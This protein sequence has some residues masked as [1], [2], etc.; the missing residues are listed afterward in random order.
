M[1]TS[2][3]SSMRRDSATGVI[4]TD[5]A[6][7]SRIS[8]RMIP[9]PDE[10]SAAEGSS[11]SDGFEREVNRRESQ[12]LGNLRSHLQGVPRNPLTEADVTSPEPASLRGR[13]LNRVSASAARDR[14]IVDNIYQ[15][16][17]SLT[18]L[19]VVRIQRMWRGYRTRKTMDMI[20]RQGQGVSDI[21]VYEVIRSALNYGKHTIDLPAFRHVPQGIYGAVMMY[22]KDESP[23]AVH[24][25]KAIKEFC[26]NGGACC[27]APGTKFMFLWLLGTCAALFLVPGWLAITFKTIFYDGDSPLT[28]D[29]LV[30]WIM[31]F[32]LICCLGIGV[33]QAWCIFE[34]ERFGA[35]ADFIL[36]I[37]GMKKSLLITHDQLKSLR[38]NALGET[39]RALYHDTPMAVIHGLHTF[40]GL[41]AVF[42][43]SGELGA[44]NLLTI[45]LVIVVMIMYDRMVITQLEITEAVSKR[46]GAAHFYSRTDRNG[47]MTARDYQLGISKALQR[48]SKTFRNVHGMVFSVILVIYISSVILMFYVGGKKASPHTLM[49]S[50]CYYFFTQ[51]SFWR[52]NHCYTAVLRARV[53]MNRLFKVIWYF[54]YYGDEDTFRFAEEDC[55]IIQES[56]DMKMQRH[57]PHSFE[58]FSII[59]VILLFLVIWL[60]YFGS[61]KGDFECKPLYVDCER[62]DPD[63]PSVSFPKNPGD[64]RVKMNFRFN[65]FYAC[66]PWRPKTETLFRCAV[67]ISNTGTFPR[68]EYGVRVTYQGW[69]GAGR[70]FSKIFKNDL[71]VN[72]ACPVLTNY[73]VRPFRTNMELRPDWSTSKLGNGKLGDISYENTPSVC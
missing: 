54:R 56:Q 7:G 8:D 32:S 66:V 67:A 11:S 36:A 71:S 24:R 70:G 69:R 60:I 21:V 38:N 19:M 28:I 13:L 63:A 4:N 44:I 49:L 39:K 61:Q 51:I 22:K 1:S 14:R 30:S 42:I 16:M 9:D 29:Q 34:Q 65:F 72:Q 59:F 55:T 47:N 50:Y 2:G 10:M 43:F 15:S 20:R 53:S 41:I 46:E 48:M 18:N 27:D 5:P 68:E 31:L 45:F 6:Q 3:G 73:A 33:L 25:W 62:Y 17:P 64:P 26:F 52:F 12:L 37:L 40:V 23:Y 35:K 58:L 57:Q